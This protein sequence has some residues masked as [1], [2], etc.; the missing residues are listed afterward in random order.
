M[1]EDIERLSPEEAKKLL[2]IKEKKNKLA[3]L[4]N[5]IAKLLV[6]GE[7][8]HYTYLA[9]VWECSPERAIFYAKQLCELFD[10][11]EYRRGY[12]RYKYV[13]E[14]KRKREV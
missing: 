8:L 4:Y 12:L 9:L 7:E 6:S 11:L 14:K 3:R 13:P 10:F 2:I 1:E 5:K